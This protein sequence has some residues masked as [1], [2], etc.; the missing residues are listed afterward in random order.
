[1]GMY[2]ANRI[3]QESRGPAFIAYLYRRKEYK[4]RIFGPHGYISEKRRESD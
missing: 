4:L 1:M 3:F 2:Q